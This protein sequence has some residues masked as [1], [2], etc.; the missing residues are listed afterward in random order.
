MVRKLPSFQG[1]Q[2]V[3]ETASK[4]KRSNR[5]VDT[6][7][8]LMLRKELWKMGLRFRKNVKGL[9]GKPDIVFPG[10]KVAIFCD[11]DFWHGR[12]WEQLRTKLEAG[13]NSTYWT[14]KIAAN[15][16]RDT[17]SAKLLEQDGWQV[18]R[19]WETDIKRDVSA[20]A[21]L[22]RDSVFA[23]RAENRPSQITDD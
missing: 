9:P 12:N 6:V 19:L 22:V 14:A 16:E 17:R 21:L 10:P 11:G 8:E 20:V 23:R 13:A 5:A 15:V 18:L 3:S 4:A 1:L 7:P 2:P